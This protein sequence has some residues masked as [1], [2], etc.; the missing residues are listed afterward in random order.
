[1]T[2]DNARTPD[3]GDFLLALITK[4]RS[5]SPPHI[6]RLFEIESKRIMDVT[7]FL[8]GDDW[9]EATE[10]GVKMLHCEAC[11]LSY[12]AKVFKAHKTLPQ[13]EA[14]MAKL[15]EEITKNAVALQIGTTEVRQ[16]AMEVIHFADEYLGGPA[17]YKDISATIVKDLVDSGAHDFPNFKSETRH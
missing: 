16:A 7:R 8:S 14:F 10:F 6:S 2:N 17:N 5:V 4:A 12:L 9:K 15:I 13:R 11:C 1:M 3:A